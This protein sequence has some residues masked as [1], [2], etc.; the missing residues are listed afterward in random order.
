MKF[1]TWL[2]NS[3]KAKA[4]MVAILGILAAALAGSVET[5]VALHQIANIVMAL[6]L[7]IAAEDG[8]AKL[9]GKAA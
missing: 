5:A 6:I 2:M 8:A 1:I 3:R 4:A 9:A 7:G